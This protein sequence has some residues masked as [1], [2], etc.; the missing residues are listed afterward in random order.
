VLAI[1]SLHKKNI[2]HRDLKPQNIMLDANGHIKLADFGLSE[3]GLAKKINMSEE[4]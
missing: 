4:I 1:D 2:I 3:V